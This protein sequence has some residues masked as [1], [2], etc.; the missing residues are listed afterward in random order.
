[1][2]TSNYLYNTQTVLYFDVLLE[3]K[4]SN[5]SGNQMGVYNTRYTTTKKTYV[6]HMLVGY[7]MAKI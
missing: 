1:M 4:L 6:F 2:T 3:I 5:M 7:N